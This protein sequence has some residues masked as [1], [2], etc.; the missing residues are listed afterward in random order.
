MRGNNRVSRGRT[1]FNAYRASLETWGG[2]DDENLTDLL[3]DL[4]HLVDAMLLDR[5]IG[6]T[7]DSLL[8][9]AR[10]HHNAEKNE[11]ETP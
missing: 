7:F 3:A 6:N 5:E 9:S 2:D 10:M 8:D 11:T 4:M 1:A